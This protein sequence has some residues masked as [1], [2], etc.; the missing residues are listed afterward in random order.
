MSHTP[1]THLR[2]FHLVPPSRS[3]FR[4][5]FLSLSLSVPLSLFSLSLLHTLIIA[6]TFK[7]FSPIIFSIFLI[8]CYSISPVFS[9]FYH[10]IVSSMEIMY[11]LLVYHRIVVRA[12]PCRNDSVYSIFICKGA[13][14]FFQFL[15][16][17]K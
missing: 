10:L 2:S 11:V 7:S 6:F 3:L 15:F 4:S 9:L 12:C 17:K 5:L 1:S 13:L 8:L 16:M 14:F